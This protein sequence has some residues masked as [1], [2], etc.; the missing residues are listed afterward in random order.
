M[1]ELPQSFDR[2][3]ILRI[4]GRGGM[5]T[6]YLARDERLGREVALKVLSGSE[7]PSEEQR[8]R[9]LREARTAAA[10]RHPNVA[11]IYE[12][13]E[14]AD[15]TPFIAM[16]YCEGDTLT[17]R[18]HRKPVDAAAFVR[19]ARQI[20]AGLAA[21][22][23]TGVI[24]RDIKSA[25]IILESD[26][27]VK[28]LDF[29]LAKMLPLESA[30][31][32]GDKPSFETTSGHFFGTLH[33]I[34][35]EQARGL[36]ADARSDLFAVGVVLYEMACGR[37]PFNADAPLGVLER[38][39]DS[40]PE[41]FQP[42]DPAFP[43]QAGPIIGKLLQKKPDDRYL[44]ADLLLDDLNRIPTPELTSTLPFGRSSLGRTIQRAHPFRLAGI[45]IG[46]VLLVA[47]GLTWFLTRGRKLPDEPPA[48]IRSMA[49]LPLENLSSGGG[50]EFLSVGLA[51]ALVT[52]LQQIPSL[53]VRPTSA[54]LEYHNKKV[55]PKTVGEKLKVDGLLE[56]HYLTS[57]DRVRVNLQLTDSRTGYGVWAGTIDGK[58]DDLLHLIDD[59]S[60]RTMQALNQQLGVQKVSGSSSEARTANAQAY[61]EYLKS[62]ALIGSLVPQDHEAQVAA[63][64]HAIELDPSFAAAYADLAIALSLGQVRGLESGPNTIE[65]AEWY[66]RQAVR[67]DPNLAEAHLALGRTLVRAP[68]RYRES[69][70]ENLAALRLKPNDSGAL[71]TVVSYFVSSGDMQKAQC[72]GD[73]LVRIDPSAND[74]RS[75]GYWNV[76]A[77]DPEGSL[78]N[79]KYALA[80]KETELAGHDMLALGFLLLGNIDSAEAE[81]QKASALNPRHYVGKSLAAMIAA[82]RGQRAAAE[83]HIASFAADAQ[84]NHFAAI[85]VALCYAKLG[86][87][88]R[89]LE[90]IRRDSD[91]GNHTWY[92]LVKHPWLEPLQGDAEFQQ[93]VKKMKAD[94]DDVRDD[95]IGVYQLI[96]PEKTQGKT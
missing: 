55:E 83:R 12:V 34:A 20:A 65:T 96:C 64:R 23:R 32:H 50:D 94:I 87:R 24:H 63:L 7:L 89:A 52:Q 22:H 9:F 86:D 49:V 28:I 40:E 41:S 37:L 80:S 81:Q 30:H 39:R 70:R 72:V 15:G 47:A 26:G 54:V 43:P 57:G 38:I 60:S 61:E 66:A 16:E 2:F 74:A 35:P 71:Y 36:T 14:A 21:A 31:S 48:P 93:I 58:R 84:H 25:N 88:K 10:I 33:Y 85:R 62:R 45:I 42:L 6:V 46:L 51:D 29:G 3:T 67:L 19:I 95:V 1:P 13:D 75:R 17:Q 68:D 92:F 4:L 59:V 27:V 5:G 91:L 18:L 76:N 53:Q 11:T 90:W 82:A 44:S 56:G 73:R 78:Q 8:A 79:A 77:V 69:M